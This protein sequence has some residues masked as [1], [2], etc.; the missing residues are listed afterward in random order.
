M[1]TIIAGTFQ[2]QDHAQAAIAEILSAGFPAAQTTTFV[3]NPPEQHDQNGLGGDTDE[4][5]GTHHAPGGA[6]SDTVVGG[7]IGAGV[8]IATLP[9]PGPGAALAGVGVDADAGSLAGALANLHDATESER[10]GTGEDP[11]R[12]EQ[13]RRRSGIL[14][15]VCVS[16]SAQ[17]A[18]A[19][20]ILR[21]EGGV[22]IEQ[23]EG[24]ISAGDWSDF[25]PLRPVMRID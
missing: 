21:G 10:K 18:T 19:V 7:A 5:P 15:A 3:I 16:D 24:T 8:G 11:E 20:R 12:N 17:Q 2:Q 6:T 13:P 1:T 9:L 14:V 4:S 23:A 25:N 22:D